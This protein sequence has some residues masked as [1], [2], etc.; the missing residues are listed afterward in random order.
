MSLK[1]HVV[2][3]DER[4]MNWVAAR[5]DGAPNPDIA[6]ADLVMFTGGED[7]SPSLY[8]SPCHP[9]THSNLERDVEEMKAFD[10]AFHL[11]KSMVGICRGAQFLCVMS[12]GELVQDQ[13]NPNFLHDMSI[14]NGG[15]I[16]VSSTHHQA[17]YPW[18]M[19]K[20]WTLL[21]WTNGLSKWHEDGTCKE[22]VNGVVAGGTEVEVA[23]FPHTKCLCIQG[24]PEMLINTEMG[25]GFIGYASEL[26]AKLI[27]REL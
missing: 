22:I 16:V 8:A 7:V 21:G 10:A 17:M 1:V 26:T 27:N 13:Q 24:H 14:P 2:G 18:R 6:T 15:K 11:G 19:K 25:D 12:G 20:E 4:Y 3:G 5:L 23:H 9:R